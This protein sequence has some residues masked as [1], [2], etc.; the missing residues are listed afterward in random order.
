M[1]N[2][3]HNNTGIIFV[4]NHHPGAVAKKVVENGDTVVFKLGTESVLIKN[5]EKLDN[6]IF[7]GVVYGF[8]LNFA[9]EF[10]A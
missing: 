8:E 1:F 4:Y 5:V 9:L 2:E 3:R 7:R 10:Q 6:D